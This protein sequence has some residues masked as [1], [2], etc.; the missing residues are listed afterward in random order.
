M[1]KYSNYFYWGML[2]VN[3][4]FAIYFVNRWAS[5][6]PT[7][8][9]IPAKLVTENSLVKDEIQM[10][11]GSSN[12]KQYAIALISSKASI[13]ADNKLGDFFKTTRSQLPEVK[14]YGLFS[15]SISDLD[16]S[17]FKNNLNLDFEGKI[18]NSELDEYWEQTS[19]RY[20]TP[21]II[22]VKNKNGLFASDDLP[23]I[24]KALTAY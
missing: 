8:P 10:L 6:K 13:C 21:A 18:M 9:R 5:A 22:V 23:E 2:V 15:R 11:T 3:V 20:E 14:L 17:N 16:I 7:A 4:I 24:R 12:Q 19:Q 1:R